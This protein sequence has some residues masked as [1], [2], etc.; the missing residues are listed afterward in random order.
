MELGDISDMDYDS[1]SEH[2]SDSSMD[3]SEDSLDLLDETEEQ[4][5]NYTSF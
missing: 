4:Y 3:I 2:H 5:I 1:D